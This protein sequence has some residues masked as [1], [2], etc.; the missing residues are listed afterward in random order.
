M[1]FSLAELAQGQADVSGEEPGSILEMDNEEHL[2]VEGPIKYRLQAS[3]AGSELVVRGSVSCRVSFACGRC[4]DFFTANVTD[5]AFLRAVEVEEG[6]EFVDLTPDIR[7]SMILAF[8]L[9]PLCDASCKGIC[10]HC[11]MN[12]NKGDCSCSVSWDDRR[13]DSLNKLRLPHSN[14]E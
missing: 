14:R 12:L 8:P 13:W 5:S 11:G 2:H 4:G 3:L 7:E 9:N 10:V 1:I 6:M